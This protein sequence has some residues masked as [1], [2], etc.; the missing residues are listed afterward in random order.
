M[1]IDEAIKRVA[2][3][4]KLPVRKDPVKRSERTGKRARQSN[5]GRGGKPPFPVPT[6]PSPNKDGEH[7]DGGAPGEEVTLSPLSPLGRGAGGEG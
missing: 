5:A 2:R 7:K 3:G 4:S 1:P 6:T